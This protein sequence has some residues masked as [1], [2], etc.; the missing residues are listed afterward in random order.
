VGYWSILL[1]S[2]NSG[3]ASQEFCI[4][5]VSDEDSLQ[6]IRSVGYITMELMHKTAYEGSL[7]VRDV[8]RWPLNSMAAQ[9]LR[10]TGNAR[11]I[12]KLL[13]VK[14]LLSFKAYLLIFLKH[15]LF[16][17][18]GYMIGIKQNIVIAETAVYRGPIEI[19]TI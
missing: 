16:S 13:E 17:C 3:T 7:E 10:L 4:K 2:T 15:P 8:E 5:P 18:K 11:S 1:A 14:K 6:N 19:S 9:F 12:D